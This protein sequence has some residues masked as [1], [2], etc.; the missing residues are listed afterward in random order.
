MFCAGQQAAI[1]TGPL[2]ALIAFATDYA[3]RV[4]TLALAL[5]QN[6]IARLTGR[7]VI[8]SRKI[9]PRLFFI[10][11]IIDEFADFTPLAKR[12]QRFGEKCREQDG[13]GGERTR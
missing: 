8:K 5:S 11:G 1:N 10:T 2:A 7:S 9:K 12:K 3:I 13:R 6:A 4:N